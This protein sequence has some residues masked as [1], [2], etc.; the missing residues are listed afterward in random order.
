[1]F[2]PM[3]ER[4]LLYPAVIL[5]EPG[6]VHITVLTPDIQGKIPILIIPKTNHNPYSFADTIIAIL[7]S[8]IFDKAKINIKKQG[9][10]FFGIGDNEYMKLVY[11]NDNKIA[12]KTSNTIEF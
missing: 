12:E 9:I 5:S 11:E 1:M 8:D 2:E 10:F 7:Q 4:D 6:S 3:F